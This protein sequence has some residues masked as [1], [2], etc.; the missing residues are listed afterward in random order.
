MKRSVPGIDEV[1]GTVSE[2]V[3]VKVSS[4]DVG[5]F[6]VGGDSLT[7]AHLS[8]ILEERFDAPVDLFTIYGAESIREIHEAMLQVHRSAA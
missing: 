6:D 1:L 8:L 2:V 4:A 5:F 7:A 3:G